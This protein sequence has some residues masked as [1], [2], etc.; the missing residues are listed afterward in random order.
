MFGDLD[1]PLNVSCGF[2]SITWASCFNFS[3][4]H[5]LFLCPKNSVKA[6]V[7][8]IYIN[9][10]CECKCKIKLTVTSVKLFSERKINRNSK[11]FNSNEMETENWTT[12]FPRTTQVRHYRK[13]SDTVSHIIITVLSRTLS[14]FSYWKPSVF[15]FYLFMHTSCWPFY[16][17]ALFLLQ[18]LSCN[19]TR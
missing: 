7:A 4:G 1:C 8:A 18:I 3:I 19:I 10:T 2:V 9:G 13:G 5:L 16:K 14:L 6:S 11:L 12:T 17:I 15:L